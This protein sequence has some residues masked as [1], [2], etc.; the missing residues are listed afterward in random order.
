MA[1]VEIMESK[2]KPGDHGV[3]RGPIPNGGIYQPMIQEDL[4]L[5]LS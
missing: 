5:S 4:C 3:C 1:T 2:V